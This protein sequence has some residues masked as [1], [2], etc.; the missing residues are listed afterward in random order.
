MNKKGL[1]KR[2]FMNILLKN[3]VKMV[4]LCKRCGRVLKSNK[5]I[6]LGYGPTCYRISK[7]HDNTNNIDILEEI[8]FLKMEIKMLKKLIRDL[9]TNS[10]TCNQ[11]SPIL[12]IRKEQSDLEKDRN[13]NQ[14][15][16]VI[17]ELKNLFQNCD[18]DIRSLL[19]P[20]QIEPNLLKTSQLAIA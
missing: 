18:G 4:V 5:S 19:K 12:R 14:M 6:K 10:F 16:E 2:P 11:S 7:I 1:R 13:N 9:K 15:S 20:I 8:K 17:H 3:E